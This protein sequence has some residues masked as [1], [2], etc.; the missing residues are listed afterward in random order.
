MKIAAFRVAACK[1]A[2]GH[3]DSEDAYAMHRHWQKFT[4]KEDE[5]AA[6]VDQAAAWAEGVGEFAAYQEPNLPWLKK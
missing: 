3:S 2:S 4:Y 1:A 5:L 6:V